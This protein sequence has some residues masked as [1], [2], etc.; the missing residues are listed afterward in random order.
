MKA[1]T[2]ILAATLGI[3]G[4]A[5]RAD[6]LY[7]TR[8]YAEP[9]RL[10]G[11]LAL[12]DLDVADISPGRYFDLVAS[13]A[14]L[15]SLRGRGITCAILETID[16]DAAPP[17][18]YTTYDELTAEIQTF[19]TL[20]PDICRLYDLGTSWEGRHIWA[21]K[22]SD[23]PS[24]NEAAEKDILIN[25][26]HHAR[27]IMTVEI[28]LHLAR[29]LLQKYPG[30]PDVK[31]VV[32]NV[33]TWIAPMLNPDGNNWVWT[34]YNM[35]RKNRRDNGGG[36]YG[37]DLNRNYDYHWGDASGCSHTPSSDSYC[38]PSAFSEPEMA[39]MRDLINNSAHQFEYNLSYHSSGRHIC[40]PWNW[41][42]S[43]P[44]EPDITY[45]RNLA[46]YLLTG[47]TGWNHGNFYAC[48]GYLGSG[49]SDDWMYD[50][51][52]H[53]KI[54]GMTCEVDTAFQPPASQIP[55]T[56]AEQYNVS[57]RL[58]KLGVCALGDDVHFYTRSAPGAVDLCWEAA[59][60]SLSGFNLYRRD[61]AGDAATS[62]T[63]LNDAL[64]RGKSP[65]R[66]RDGAAAPG[67]EYEYKLEAVALTGQT[68]TY[69]PVRGKTSGTAKR[70]LTLYQS[71]PNPAR[72][73]A[74]IRFDLP[75]S[76]GE[77]SLSVFDAAGRKV[78]TLSHGAMA[79]GN[80]DFVW[81]LTDDAGRKL[82]PGV[83]IYRLEGAGETI[84]RRMVLAE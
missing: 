30:D 67:R 70:A 57:M 48:L 68:Q 3:A 52:G 12:L 58:L 21:L 43:Y 55:I 84:A 39:A 44:A 23:N 65:W 9:A 13:P 4:A 10:E 24:A 71:W 74:T 54:W 8:A 53:T 7:L 11:D 14:D 38:G 82:A 15:D 17:A 40:Y 28:N 79:A 66:W 27:E 47:L 59:N 72:V 46:T 31:R 25:G 1:L 2:I 76:A 45:Y 62:Y 22:I 60:T 26:N 83:Y 18:E 63:R 42:N 51:A 80:H 36:V 35:W 77:V 56:C 61:A 6:T 32:D 78:R 37:V 64:I 16:T 33:E 75:A 29:Q 19:P 73:T 49:T 20:Y 5:A 41:V 50:G 34:N 81:D 69:G